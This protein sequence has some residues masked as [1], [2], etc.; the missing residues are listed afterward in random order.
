MKWWK[1]SEVKG[2]HMQNERMERV[3]YEIANEIQISRK[4]RTGKAEEKMESSVGDLMDF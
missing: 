2:T 3:T 4:K 1:N